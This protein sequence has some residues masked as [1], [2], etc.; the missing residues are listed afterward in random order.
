M[1][2]SCR[3][4]KDLERTAHDLLLKLQMAIEHLEHAQK[5]TCEPTDQRYY[6]LWCGKHIETAIKTAISL[7]AELRGQQWSYLNHES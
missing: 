1:Q 6:L 2:K 3:E 5:P 4:F 7:L